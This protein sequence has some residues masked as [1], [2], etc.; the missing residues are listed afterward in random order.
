M[1]SPTEM[2]QL[3]QAFILANVNII[4]IGRDYMKTQQPVH[5][6]RK[7]RAFPPFQHAWKSL[8]K[9]VYGSRTLLTSNILLVYLRPILWSEVQKGFWTSLTEGVVSDVRQMRTIDTGVR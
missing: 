9:T 7:K 8:L 5:Y 1:H 3:H 2:L 4:E 6:C